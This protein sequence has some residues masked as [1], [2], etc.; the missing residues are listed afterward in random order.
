ML[1]RNPFGPPVLCPQTRRGPNHRSD[2]QREPQDT[3][4]RARFMAHIRASA[5]RTSASNDPTKGL[6]QLPSR[7]RRAGT[8]RIFLPHIGVSAGDA[9]LVSVFIDCRSLARTFA[10]L[11]LSLVHIHTYQQV[12]SGLPQR[13]LRQRCGSCTALQI[14]IYNLAF[15][16]RA[17]VIPDA[18]GVA[19][20]TTSIPPIL[21]LVVIIGSSSRSNS[22][23]TLS[24]AQKPVFLSDRCESRRRCFRLARQKLG[25]VLRLRIMLIV[26]YARYRFEH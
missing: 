18:L 3:V 2:R 25:R 9:S 4:Y 8:P 17:S 21:P 26:L 20:A 24:G 10:S 19:T 7:R 15:R 11:W 12:L 22:R 6:C 13:R 14:L 23:I 5:R 16:V 1:S